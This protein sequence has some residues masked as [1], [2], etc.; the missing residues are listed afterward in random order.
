MFTKE[1][2]VGLYL[3]LGLLVYF[4]WNVFQKDFNTTQLIVGT[5][6]SIALP[7]ILYI[8]MRN[9]FYDAALGIIQI[10]PEQR[11]KFYIQNGCMTIIVFY[12]AAIGGMWFFASICKV[13]FP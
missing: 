7:T 12:C 2:T 13:L 4:L 11:Q 1:R 3:W 8:F 10:P 6:G 9:M 5:V